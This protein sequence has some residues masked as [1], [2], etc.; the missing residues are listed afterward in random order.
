MTDL[1]DRLKRARLAAGYDTATDAA[2]AFGWNA[3]TYKSAE[4]GQ[5]SLTRPAA[6]RYA[7]AFHVSIDWLLTGRGAMNPTR[8]S[9]F[10]HIPIYRW[11][12]IGSHEPLRQQLLLAQPQG[13]VPVPET[14]DISEDGFA[15]IVEDDSMLDPEGSPLSLMPGDKI[16]I[17]PAATPIAGEIVLVRDGARR[18][19]RI[20][21]IK[22]EN[23]DGSPALVELLPLNPAYPRRE[24]SGDKIM[25]VMTMFIRSAR[26]K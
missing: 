24:L 20:M 22:T 3:N 19:L 5:R 12:D 6:I 8:A 23:V 7:K 10:R 11:E 9:G 14:E 1:A 4:N 25:G 21:H 15:L 26:K 2:K 16:I 18:L 17:D 13:V